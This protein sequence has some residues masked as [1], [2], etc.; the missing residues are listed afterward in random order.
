MM[1]VI[2][3]LTLDVLHGIGTCHL[4]TAR[5]NDWPEV[6]LIRNFVRRDVPSE[7]LVIDINGNIA[8]RLL[9]NRKLSCHGSNLHTIDDSKADGQNEVDGQLPYYFHAFFTPHPRNRLRV[10]RGPLYDVFRSHQLMSFSPRSL[11]LFGRTLLPIQ[12]ARNELYTMNCCIMLRRAT[13]FV[14]SITYR[15]VNLPPLMLQAIIRSFKS[16]FIFNVFIC[17]F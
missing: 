12:Q 10:S 15:L 1:R 14:I 16:S 4:D 11:F 2:L 17:R 9:L 6:T 3:L 13:H 8:S 5:T 7:Q